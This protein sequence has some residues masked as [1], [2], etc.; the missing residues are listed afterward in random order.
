V[1]AESQPLLDPL[2]LPARQ[3]T[4]LDSESFLFVKGSY[5]DPQAELRLGRVGGQSIWIGPFNGEYASYQ[6][7]PGSPAE[8]DTS[9]DEN[10]NRA[11]LD[12]NCSTVERLPPDSAEAQQIMEEL[13]QNFREQHPTE[14][15]GMAILHRVDHLGEWAVVTGSVVGEGKDIIAVRQTPQGYQIAEHYHISVPLESPEDLEKRVIEPFLER[16]PEAPD[17]LFTCLDRAWLLAVGSE[18]EPPGIYQL[19]YIGTSDNTTEG[20][21]EINTIQS[22]GS[23]HTVLLSEAMLILG[24]V[25]SPEGEKIAFWGCPGN[26]AND[27]SPGEDLDV[28]VVNWDG[29]NLS[30]LT[31]DSAANESHPDWSPNGQQLVFDSDSSGNSQLYIMY[32]DGSNPRA[33]TDEPGQ[34]K[35]PKWSPDGQWIAYHCML[36]SETR[37]CIVSPDGQPAGSPISGTTPVWSPSGSVGGMRLAFLCF[38]DG[39]SDIC[40]ARPDGSEM[41]KLTS[42]PADEH[43]LAWSPDGNW[44]AFVS[45]RDDDVDVYKICVTCPGESAAI[46]LTDEPRPAGWP[47]WSPNGGRVAYVDLGGQ[48]LLLVNADRSDAMYL[49]SGVFSPPVWQLTYSPR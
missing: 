36:G 6:V 12:V 26:L 49:A 2:V 43:T 38:Q 22:D 23:N 24:L 21:T 14:A 41:A 5:V 29:S 18:T 48:D 25:S 20:L 7:V 27:C 30:N 8:S 28:W 44:L 19:A 16:L 45:N 4:W 42:S 3:F 34:N 9:P 13:I 35:E 17:A 10:L 15:M 39:Y 46:R 1:C 33:L 47:A 11:D 40:T 31:E 37:I 32:S